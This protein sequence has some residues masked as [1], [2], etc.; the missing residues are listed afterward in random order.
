MSNYAF[1]IDP[2]LLKYGAQAPVGMAQQ[3][4]AWGQPNIALPEAMPSMSQQLLNTDTAGLVPGG[5]AGAAP[6]L[7]WGNLFG[8]L[9]STNNKTGIRS[10]GWGGLALGLGQAGVSAF[11]G[12][13]QY[14]AA[15]EALDENKRQFQMN[16]DNQRKLVNSQL[17]DRQRARVASNSGAYQSVGDYMKKNGV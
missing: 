4:G 8:A 2:N 13:K 9:G 6:E 1:G 16:F 7:G 14:S 17:E 3:M 12:M 10:D 15:T 11:M 5:G